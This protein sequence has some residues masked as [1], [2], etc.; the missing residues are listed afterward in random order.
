MNKRL[1]FNL[2]SP[3]LHA[4][5]AFALLATSKQFYDKEKAK[6]LKIQHRIFNAKYEHLENYI[7]QLEV[8]E[9]GLNN[10][11][12][13]KLKKLLKLKESY[14]NNSISQQ[15]FLKNY[16]KFDLNMHNLN[17]IE[18]EFYI[19]N[20]QRLVNRYNNGENNENVQLGGNVALD[21]LS[22][23]LKIKLDYD[24]QRFQRFKSHMNKFYHNIYDART[25][26][27]YMHNF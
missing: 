11:Y 19:K 26:S 15:E 21:S 27:N 9:Y 13:T 5:N 12:T 16:N 6:E 18:L 17:M 24:K 4:Q 7:K 3:N 20:L 22:K 14:D 1:I 2:I 23:G 8:F 25:Y 10:Q